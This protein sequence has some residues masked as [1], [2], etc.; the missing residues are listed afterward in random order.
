MAVRYDEKI[1]ELTDE[2]M[3]A[4]MRR[5]PDFFQTEKDL[6]PIPDVELGRQKRQF[7]FQTDPPFPGAGGGGQSPFSIRK[8]PPTPNF[9]PISLAINGFGSL[10]QVVQVC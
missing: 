10:V 9:A 6:P 1:I 7:P 8:C 3:A 5:N 4:A 2:Q